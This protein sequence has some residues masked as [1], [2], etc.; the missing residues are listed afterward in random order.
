MCLKKTITKD[1]MAEL[2]KTTNKMM[3]GCTLENESSQGN[4][5]VFAKNQYCVLWPFIEPA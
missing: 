1:Y 5:V 4:E 2:L 3:I